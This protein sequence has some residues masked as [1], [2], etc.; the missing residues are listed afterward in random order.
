MCLLQ[1]PVTESGYTA[2]GAP[3]SHLSVE[4]AK[5]ITEETWENYICDQK[6]KDCKNKRTSLSDEFTS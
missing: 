1:S 5:Q 2:I 3:V 4:D 6:Q